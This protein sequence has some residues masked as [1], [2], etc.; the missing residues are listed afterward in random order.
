MHSKQ[1]DHIYTCGGIH[2]DISM[3]LYNIHGTRNL[4]MNS[5][6]LF[7]IIIAFYCEIQQKV[8]ALNR[9]LI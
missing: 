9:L 6:L 3:Y 2:N 1:L 7:V 4:S 5:K 8:R